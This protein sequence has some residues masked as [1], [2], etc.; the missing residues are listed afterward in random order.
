MHTQA[1]KQTLRHHWSEGETF[2]KWLLFAGIIGVVV[3][4]VS[5]AFY[6]C[7][8]WATRARE[9]RQRLRRAH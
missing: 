7:F 5:S 4:G 2:L 3:G 8:H 9:E 6:H 1:W